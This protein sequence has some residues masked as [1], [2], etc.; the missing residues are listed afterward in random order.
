MKKKKSQLNPFF[1]FSLILS[2]A[3]SFSFEL[4]RKLVVFGN[5]LLGKR[6]YLVDHWDSVITKY[7]E[8]EILPESITDEVNLMITLQFILLISYPNFVICLDFSYTSKN[9]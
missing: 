2:L 7:R 8:T 9:E 6:R 3:L 5:A 1:L 4:N